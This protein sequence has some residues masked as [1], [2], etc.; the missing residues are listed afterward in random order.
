MTFSAIRAYLWI[1]PQIIVST[2]VHGSINLITALWD[3]DGA[4][5][6]R[7]ARHWA[8]SLVK[9]AGIRLTINGLEK[10]LPGRSYVFVCNH[11]SYMDTPVVLGHIPANFRFMAKQELFKIPFIG[12]HLERAGHIAV[13]LDDP[14][15]ALKVLSSAGTMMRERGLSVLVFPEGGRSESGVMQPFKEGAAYLAIKGGVPVVPLGII[16]IRDVLP[17]HSSHV[18]PGPVTLNIGDPIPVDGLTTAARADLTGRLF[19]EVARLSGQWR[20]PEAA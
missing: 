17:M 8:R 12:W 16:G 20:P 5:Q 10:I 15:A 1:A 9:A 19:E 14:R 13:P 11:V 7:I 4:I 2:A 6:L 3:K 18:R